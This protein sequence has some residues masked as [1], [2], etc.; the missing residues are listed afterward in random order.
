V[1]CRD[2]RLSTRSPPRGRPRRMPDRVREAAGDPLEVDKDSIA[3]LLLQPPQRC[4][5]ERVVIHFSYLDVS[6]DRS[7]SW[8]VGEVCISA[9]AICTTVAPSGSAGPGEYAITPAHRLTGIA[10]NNAVLHRLRSARLTPPRGINSRACGQQ[11]LWRG[12]SKPQ[13][14]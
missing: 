14:K 7:A 8:T 3:L 11:L 2:N 1:P 13:P 5:K 6:V 10:A 4:S 12:S 9:I